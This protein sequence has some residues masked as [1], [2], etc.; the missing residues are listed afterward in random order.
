MTPIARSIAQLLREIA[1]RIDAGNSEVNEEQ[2]IQL[3]QLVAHQPLSKEQAARHLNMSTSRFDTLI[4]EGWLPKGRKKLGWKEKIWYEDEL[5]KCIE[6]F[7][8]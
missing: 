5:D 4:R 6:R 8:E 2:A 3:M 7:N 1:D